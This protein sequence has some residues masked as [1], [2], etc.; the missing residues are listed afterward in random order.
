M[1]GDWVLCDEGLSHN[2]TFVNG[3]RVPGRRLLRGGDVIA[4]GDTQ[5][6]FCAASGASIDRDADGGSATPEIALTP[7]QR[8]VLAALCRPMQGG[9]YAAPASNQQIADE[10]VLSVETVKGTLTALFERFGLEALP[11]NQKRA[12]LAVRAR[13]LPRSAVDDAREGVPRVPVTHTAPSPAAIAYGLFSHRERLPDLLGRPRIE[14]PARCDRWCWRRTGGRRRRPSGQG[15]A[16]PPSSRGSLR[17]AGRCGRRC[18]PSRSSPIGSPRRST[19]PTSGPRASP[20][21]VSGPVRGS[22]RR[23]S[24][25]LALG[26]PDETA[27]GRERRHAAR[28]RAAVPLG[29][30]VGRSAPAR[31]GWALGDRRHPQRARA[32][33]RAASAARPGAAGGRRVPVRHRSGRRGARPS[34]RPTRCVPCADDA[35]RAEADRR[36]LAD[37]RGAWRRRSARP[38]C[39]SELVTQTSP[40]ASATP[41]GRSPDVAD[42]LRD[43]DR[44]AAGRGGSPDRARR[45]R[46]PR[47]ATSAASATETERRSG[48]FGTRSASAGGRAAVTRRAVAVE[49]GRRRRPAPPRR[50]PPSA[51]AAAASPPEAAASAARPRSPADG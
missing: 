21:A 37:G 39:A 22:S 5:L 38:S 16:R 12:A 48:A 11:Q 50:A 42:R 3:E 24:R 44:R 41:F 26:D 17:G 1:G 20:I 34:P 45:R 14:A 46:S 10:L 7:A 29:P 30:G 15:G 9:G 18:R 35:R 6:A 2:G 13:E 47:V 27:A 19:A 25:P 4:V 49:L 51:Q 28:H 43:P 36:R 23:T 31:P 32:R 33:R 40:P 8:R